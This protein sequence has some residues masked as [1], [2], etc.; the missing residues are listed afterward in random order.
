MCLLVLNLTLVEFTHAAAC[1]RRWSV[2]VVLQ[3]PIVGL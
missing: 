3:Y 1:G 2:L